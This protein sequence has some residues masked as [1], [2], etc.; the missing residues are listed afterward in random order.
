MLQPDKYARRSFEIEA[1]RVTK[2]NMLEIMKWCD[3]SVFTGD[4]KDDMYIKVSTQGRTER[5]TRAY[6]GDWVLKMGKSFKI[7]TDKSFRKCFEKVVV[8]A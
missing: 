7:Y 6:V 4:D 2:D 8:P 1:V 3:G 5:Q